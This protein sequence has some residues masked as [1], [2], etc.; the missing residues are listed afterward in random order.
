M[1][2]LKKSVPK[3]AVIY[4]HFPHYRKAVFDALSLNDRYDFVFYYDPLGIDSTI[5]SGVAQVNHREAPVFSIK[6]LM[7]QK[8]IVSMSNFKEYDIFIFLGNPHVIS[9][10]VASILAKIF[11][12][13]VLFWTH[14]WLR[15]ERAPREIV[16]TIF[17]KIADA[18]LVYGDRAKTIGERK[19]YPKSK[20][21]V[22]GNSL[23]YNAHKIVRDRFLEIQKKD[24]CI[25]VKFTP[26]YFLIVS[27]L[28]HAARID[29]A[30]LAMLEIPFDCRLIVVGDGPERER[31]ESLA[32]KVNAKVEFLGPVYEEEKLAKLFM[33]CLAVVSPGK[34]GLLSI[35]ALTYG[36]PVITHND[37]DQQ[38]PEVEAVIPG[39]T[40][41][42]FE[43]DNV[44]DLAAKMT[45][46]ENSQRN[47]NDPNDIGWEAIKMVERNFTPDSQVT[48]I[49]EALDIC[50]S[51]N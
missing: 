28:I 47:L 30:I 8:N 37:Y 2:K 22:I 21:Y 25:N 5:K 49:V 14:G 36:A 4:T 10:W 50:T 48:K 13:P 38:M 12:K 15:Q 35:H 18:L 29:L 20:I 51:E 42:L 39:I 41:E 3:V 11:N 16:R 26:P 40:G 44:N 9:T 46:F 45:K 24:N 6:R 19:G 23:D 31:L 34:V 7:W 17:Y 1:S 43:F 33:Q 32:V 27:R